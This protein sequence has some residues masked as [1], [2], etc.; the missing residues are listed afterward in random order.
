MSPEQ[1]AKPVPSPDPIIG[2]QLAEED[3]FKYIVSMRRKDRPDGHFG[4]GTIIGSQWILT[5]RHNLVDLV[6]DNETGKV[7]FTDAYPV[8][9]VPK[10]FNDMRKFPGLP[11]YE[12]EKTFCNP[13]PI[14]P[15]NRADGDVGLVKLKKPI[16]LRSRSPYNFTIIPMIN[17]E[18]DVQWN[19]KIKLAGWG[20]FDFQVGRASALLLKTT[21][22]N[23]T[24]DQCASYM[25]IYR[26][27]EQICAF[28]YNKSGCIGDS[29]GP[30]VLRK[31]GTL[32]YVQVGIISYVLGN[33]T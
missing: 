7:T 21:I 2:G 11:Y 16:P 32:D 31:L 9:V 19:D 6:V 18:R 5:V 4:A 23:L 10:Y 28:G 13:M 24:D 30:G 22:Q 17:N 27:A 33:C 15:K 8:T 20:V 12:S 14:N 1:A 29:G 26:K 25:L 3:E